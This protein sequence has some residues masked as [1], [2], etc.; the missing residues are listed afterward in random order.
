LKTL[1]LGIGNILM[2]DEGV[3]VRAVQ[4]LA[5]TDIVEKADL[6]DGGTRGL[7]LLSYFQEYPRII[8]IDAACDGRPPG[9]VS[10]I[11]PRFAADFPATLTAHDI[12]LKD[13]IEAAALVGKLPRIELITISIDKVQPMALDLSEAARA[14]LDQV[15][16]TARH[17][18]S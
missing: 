10:V 3:G 15:E 11:R 6:V 14:S 18:L 2:G 12:G 16:K 9:T 13:L 1:V 7:N 4:H 5:A 17:I 8:L